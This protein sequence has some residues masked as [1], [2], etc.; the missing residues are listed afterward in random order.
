M[1]DKFIELADGFFVAPQ[2]TPDDVREAAA[3]GVKVIINN[4]PDGEEFGQPKGAEI[5]AAAKACG[6]NYVA[7]P[8][9]GMNFTEGCLDTFDK[10][11][12]ASE[13]PVLAYCRT[14]TRSTVLRACAKARA[15]APAM[16]ILQEAANAGYNISGIAP[17]LAALARG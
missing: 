3:Q 16:E 5:E 17:R 6:I 7:I 13:G 11:V 10:A 4:R 9:A 12:S 2:I 15:G 8:M 14:G 1:T